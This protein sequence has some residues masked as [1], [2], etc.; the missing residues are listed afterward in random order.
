MKKT[1]IFL[2]IGSLAAAGAAVAGEQHIRHRV[3]V[4]PEHGADHVI[5]G[6]GPGQRVHFRFMMPALEELDLTE[7]QKAASKQIHE[8]TFAQVKPLM[9]QHM[10]QMDEVHS[11]L[12]ADNADA[13]AVGQRMIAAHAT[14]KQIEA[15]HDSA[16]ERFSALLTAE[17]R[18]KLEEFEKKHPKKKFVRMMH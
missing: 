11:L 16:R 3:V 2:M 17:Q 1:W 6:E 14:M 12:D 18:A 7:E 10:K 8:E 13:T 15:L 4:G 5:E 9:E